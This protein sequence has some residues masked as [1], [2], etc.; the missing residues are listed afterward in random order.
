MGKKIR[1]T[2][3]QLRQIVKNVISESGDADPFKGQ[4][5][6]LFKKEDKSPES[7]LKQVILS[8]HY[9]ADNGKIVLVIETTYKEKNQTLTYSCGT[10][11]YSLNTKGDMRGDIMVFSAKLDTLITE[12]KLCADVQSL[13]PGGKKQISIPSEN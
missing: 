8:G 7:F 5:V 10:R 1:I 6:N 12:N 2:E 11:G 9:V 13:K 3:S 4:K